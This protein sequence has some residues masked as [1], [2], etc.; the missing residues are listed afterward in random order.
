MLPIIFIS[1][2]NI[3]SKFH[4]FWRTTIRNAKKAFQKWRHRHFLVYG[5]NSPPPKK[6]WG[7]NFASLLLIDTYLY[8]INSSFWISSKNLKAFI[9]ENGNIE[10]LD[11]I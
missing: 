3:I 10:Y 11:Q 5:Y 8:I 7:G 9:Y 6:I 2:L 4:L 1:I